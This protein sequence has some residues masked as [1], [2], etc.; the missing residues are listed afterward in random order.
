[1]N[2]NP[3]ATTGSSPSVPSAP[4]S[5]LVR[6]R[7]VE[8]IHRSTTFHWV[9]NGFYVST[10]FPSAKLPAERVSPFVL[11]DYGPPR[12]FT[13]LA[14]G[15]RGVGWHPHRGFETVTLAWEGSVAHRDNAGHAGVIGPGDAQWMTAA[16]GIFHEEYHEED[17]ARRGGRMHMMQLWVNLPRKDKMA[18]PNYQGLVASQFPVVRLSNGGHVRVLAGDYEGVKGPARTFTPITMLDVELRAGEDLS[19]AL[20]PTFN[21]MAV[22]AKGAVTAGGSSRANAGAGELVLFANDGER[23]ALAAREDSHVIVLSGEALREPIVQYGP[24]VMNTMGEIEQAMLDV[25]RGKFGGI[26][27]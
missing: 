23:L 19:A 27:R 3:E 9:G 5:A 1:M 13:P 24:F 18:P 21:A 16:G 10:Y 7:S 15:K 17:F 14:Q 8:G 26:P 25:E 12:E 2:S 4:S 22:V 20:P 6:E 11:M